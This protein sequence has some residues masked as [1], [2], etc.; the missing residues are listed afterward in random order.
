MAG[1]GLDVTSSGKQRQVGGEVLRDTGALATLEVREHVFRAVDGAWRQSGE[2]RHM[3]AVRPVRRTGNDL[4]QKHDVVLPFLDLDCHHA[5]PVER[6]GKRRQLVI[7]GCEQGAA[8]VH[9][10]EATQYT[11]RRW[12]GRRT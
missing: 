4:V 5:H 3:N 11:P 2:L 12:K 7:V 6:S 10:V 1:T 9:P 8:P